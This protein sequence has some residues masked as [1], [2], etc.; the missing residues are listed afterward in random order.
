MSES[1]IK[2]SSALPADGESGKARAV[3]RA[4]CRCNGGHYFQG[5]YCP[6]DGWSSR[7]SKELA[8]A[9]ER[10][11]H[12]GQ[13]IS[14]LTLRKAGVSQATIEWTIVVMFGCTESAFDALAPQ[15]CVVKD[16]V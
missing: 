4:Y 16:K 12:Q 9:V 6:F 5:E 2:A 14:L 7:A 3:P 1:P 13:E 8:K 15:L 10:L 11:V